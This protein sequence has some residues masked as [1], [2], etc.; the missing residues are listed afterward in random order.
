MVGKII[1]PIIFVA[2]A[3]SAGGTAYFLSESLWSN[4]HTA[5][6]Y[7]KGGD[8]DKTSF[9]K[10]GG[11]EKIDYDSM[12]SKNSES[13]IQVN[14]KGWVNQSLNIKETQNNSLWLT[15]KSH[16]KRESSYWSEEINKGGKST[17]SNGYLSFYLLDI[18][19]DSL[20]NNTKFGEIIKGE[21]SL[22]KFTC[23]P[24]IT[25]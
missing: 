11:G 8:N 20:R 21:T 14:S 13:L 12:F 19:C 10:V 3:S 7:K 23:Q 25:K 2:G 9:L 18:D 16:N 5:T 17:N 1:W 24:K 22:V 15:G 6:F 4:A